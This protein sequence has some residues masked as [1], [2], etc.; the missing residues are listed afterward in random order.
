MTASVSDR[1]VVAECH[2]VLISANGTRTGICYP[3]CLSELAVVG[4]KGKVIRR[5]IILLL[6]LVW[7][8]CQGSKAKACVPGLGV[9][10]VSPSTL[11]LQ[12][13]CISKRPQIE[14]RADGSTPAAA[15]S[16]ASSLPG[17]LGCCS[18]RNLTCRFAIRNWKFGTWLN[19]A[20][21]SVGAPWRVYSNTLQPAHPQ[22]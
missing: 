15:H 6:L 2:E 10:K 19:M 20:S 3:R 7:G 12:A 4:D 17:C 9:H 13:C 1:L 11:H 5:S 14:S 8:G 16:Q 21:G 18:R 22:P